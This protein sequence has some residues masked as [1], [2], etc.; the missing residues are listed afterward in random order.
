MDTYIFS[1]TLLIP[2]FIYYT[3]N[4]KDAN[5]VKTFNHTYVKD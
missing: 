2:F 3:L 1:S 4:Q 5:R